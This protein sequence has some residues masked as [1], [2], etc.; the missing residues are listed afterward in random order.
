MNAKRDFYDYA[1]YL[2]SQLASPAPTNA[3]MTTV[4]RTRLERMCGHMQVALERMAQ[5]DR[6]KALEWF[7]RE[8][9]A[10][11]AVDRAPGWLMEE[12]TGR[13]TA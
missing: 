5:E 10:R 3:I 1:R 4:D 11:V 13:R 6:E 8:L 9:D 12:M 7:A 2:L